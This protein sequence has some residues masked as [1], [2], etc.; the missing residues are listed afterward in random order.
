MMIAKI[1]LENVTTHKNT[2]IEF[3]DG[4]NVLIGQNGSGKTTILNMIG[5]NLFDFLPGNQK[6]YLRVDSVKQPK[7]GLI[8][9]WIV[10]LHND[11]FII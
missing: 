8:K 4:L 10:G 1:E 5:Y 9:V 3:Q 2:T 7:F 6:D 11:L